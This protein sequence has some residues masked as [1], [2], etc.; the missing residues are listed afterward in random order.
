MNKDSII[1]K[2][3]GSYLPTKVLTNDDLASFLDTSDEWITQRTGIKQRHI[4]ASSEMVSDLAAEACVKAI[5]K[6][7][8]SPSEVDLIIC[9]TSTPDLTF[10]STAAIIQK[11][12]EIKNCVAFD[13]GQAACN[14][15]ITALTVG[16]SMMKANPNFKKALIIG[17]EVFSRLLDWEDRSTA[18]LFGD[19]AGCVLLERSEEANTGILDC[20]LYNDGSLDHILYADGGVG[21]TGDSG[22]VVMNGKTV[23]KE[24]V[25]KL[26]QAAEDMLKKNSVA[27]T[28]L[29]WFVP[30]Q[31]NSRIIKATAD[32]IGLPEDRIISTVDQH[33]NT[34]AASI[35]LA[36][37]W[38]QD[39]TPFKAGDLILLDA[40]GAGLSW[41]ACLIKWI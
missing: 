1:I 24:A 21:Q 20:Q 26:A 13:I 3:T 40:L 34:S 39:N 38:A 2:S 36:L 7:E 15:F 16:Q 22:K 33:A 25:Q 29:N 10:P 32:H 14:G 41:G 8:I 27:A 12:L 23:F 4:A 37:D 19:G 30:H 17:A 35:P 18:I 28:D 9:A 11:K 6:A 31:A 5:F